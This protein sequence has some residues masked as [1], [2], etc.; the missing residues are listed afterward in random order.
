MVGNDGNPYIIDWA[1]SISRSELGFFPLNL[2]YKR[3]LRDDLN[4]ITKIRLKWRPESVSA[5][6]RVRYSERSRA[7]RI[8]RAI[9]N[10]LRNRLKKMA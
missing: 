1:A 4:A 10:W 8:I 3:F 9:R 5:E 6:E 7:E 2:V